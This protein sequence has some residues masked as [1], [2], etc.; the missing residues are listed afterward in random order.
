MKKTVL[1]LICTFGFA[2]YAQAQV[3]TPQPSPHVKTTQTVGLTEITLDYSRP[4]VKER[5]IFGGLVPYGKIWRTGANE[6]TT[7]TFSDD[8]KINGEALPAGKYAI[9][10]KPGKESWE[11]YFYSDTKNWGAPKELEK[12]KIALQTEAELIPLPAGM[13]TFLI[14]FDNIR[15]DHAMLDFVWEN[16]VARIKV[17]VPTEEKTMKSIETTMS[18]DPTANDYFSAA[19]Y[20]LNADKDMEQALEWMN[21]AIEKME[22]EPPF[23][24]LHY[25]AQMQA[26]LGMDKEAIETAQKSLK[27]SKKAENDHYTSENE[28]LLKELGAS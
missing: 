2:I 13:E 28:K 1:L 27:A 18:G 20:Y 3:E 25:K 16:T 21:S 7:I 9:F 24:A 17:E 26:K 5:E 14:V 11:I 19:T 8:V 10:T 22:G 4:S 15:T 6:N 23:Y 12:E